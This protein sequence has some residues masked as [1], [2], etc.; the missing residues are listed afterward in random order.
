MRLDLRELRGPAFARFERTLLASEHREADG[1]AYE[2]ELAGPFDGRFLQLLVQTV[3][4]TTV[5]TT[6]DLTES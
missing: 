2:A 6:L 3:A 4:G 1:F 5:S